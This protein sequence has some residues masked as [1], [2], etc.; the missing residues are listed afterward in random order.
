MVTVI[1][2]SFPS[3]S[4]ILLYYTLHRPFRQRKNYP[5]ESMEI[6]AKLG[7]VL[8]DAFPDLSVDVHKPEIMLNVEVR[9]KIYIYSQVI[10]GP[11]G[12]PIGTNVTGKMVTALKRIGFDKVFDTDFAADLTIMEEAYELLDRVKKSLDE[13]N[14]KY[15][16]L[17]IN[18]S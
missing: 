15:V 9:E 2:H 8:L 11:G 12:M 10:P 3:F 1:W 17:C 16:E 14:I 18:Q 13:Y 6:N 7:E 5:L 4:F